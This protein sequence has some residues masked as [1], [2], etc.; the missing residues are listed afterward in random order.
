MLTTDPEAG[1]ASVFISVMVT[2]FCAES[3]LGNVAN[4]APHSQ[5]KCFIGSLECDLHV[6]V[7]HFFV[8]PKHFS[9]FCVSKEEQPAWDIRL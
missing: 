4:R 6:K 8:Y 5:C 2:G 9:Y 1:V 7:T 3:V